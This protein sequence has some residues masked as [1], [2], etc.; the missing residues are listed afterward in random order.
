MHETMHM[1]TSL[2][3]HTY[4]TVHVHVSI[5][6]SVDDFKWCYHLEATCSPVQ[7]G[8]KPTMHRGDELAYCPDPSERRVAPCLHRN[9]TTCPIVNMTE[10][11]GQL[12]DGFHIEAQLGSIPMFLMVVALMQLGG[13]PSPVG[14]FGWV[15]WGGWMLIQ[16]AQLLVVV[17]N[18]I[19][20][21]FETK[22]VFDQFAL[23]TLQVPFLGISVL[24][25]F[26]STTSFFLPHVQL[27]CLTVVMYWLAL[28]SGG[29]AF[30]LRPKASAAIGRYSRLRRA[31][32]GYT[33]IDAVRSYFSHPRSQQS[34]DATLLTDTT[35]TRRARARFPVRSRKH[36]AAVP[37]AS[38]GPEG[39][40][41]GAH[42]PSSSSPPP[43]PP[44][45]GLV[46]PGA[47]PT[48]DIERHDDEE[49]G[50]A[51]W[52]DSPVSPPSGGHD[53]PTEQLVEQHLSTHG[54]VRR[55][56]L[57]LGSEEAEGASSH[58]A[59]APSARPAF[60]LVL[61]GSSSHV[62]ESARLDATW[63]E[64]AP[65]DSWRG[66]YSSRQ[67]TGPDQPP[68]SARSSELLA[69]R[70]H[71]LRRENGDLKDENRKLYHTVDRH[72]RRSR[73]YD[74]PNGAF[75]T[76]FRYLHMRLFVPFILLLL[77]IWGA[78]LAFAFSVVFLPI[79]AF[80]ATFTALLLQ[81]LV[82]LWNLANGHARGLQAARLK[83]L[84][85][86]R[87]DVSG[88]LTQLAKH[89]REVQKPQLWRPGTWPLVGDAILRWIGIR[90][91]WLKPAVHRLDLFGTEAAQAA[92]NGSEA[93][94]DPSSGISA[95][96]TK[97]NVALY[98]ARDEV[99]GDFYL[100][101]LRFAPP[102][103]SEVPWWQ[104]LL[105]YLGCP[106][107]VGE[108][109]KVSTHCGNSI[110]SARAGARR[111]DADMTEEERKRRDAEV[112]QTV[113][114]LL[115]TQLALTP[116]KTVM[117]Q[118]AW[119]V[120]SMFWWL[121]GRPKRLR[122]R[123]KLYSGLG[124]FWAFSQEARREH[125]LN[126]AAQEK[127]AREF[128]IRS[129]KFED[130]KEFVE[131]L[132]QEH[133]RRKRRT[134]RAGEDGVMDG[135]DPHG[136]SELA[137]LVRQHAVRTLQEWVRSVKMRSSGVKWLEQ[138]PGTFVP[139][140]AS[141]LKWRLVGRVSAFSS[142]PGVELVWQSEHSRD[143]KKRRHFS[144][145]FVRGASPPKAE[146]LERNRGL[147][148]MLAERFNAR[149]EA[150][151]DMVRQG[152]GE[153]AL[154]ALLCE[155]DISPAE[156]MELGF[157]PHQIKG[158]HC[159]KLGVR[160]VPSQRLEDAEL[161]DGETV[162]G[163]GSDIE[164]HYFKPDGFMEVSS[165]SLT[166]ALAKT[167]AD[168]AKR[169]R[170]PL[171]DSQLNG[172]PTYLECWRVTTPKEL[173]EA[174][175]HATQRS[176]IAVEGRYFRPVA[177]ARV[178][179]AGRV[180]IRRSA[181]RPLPRWHHINVQAMLLRK[182]VVAADQLDAELR[183]PLR[184]GA[185]RLLDCAWVLDGDGSTGSEPMAVLARRQELPENAFLSCEAALKLLDKAN[186][187]II[188]LTHCWLTQAHPD[189]H[190]VTLKAVRRYLNQLKEAGELMGYGQ[191]GLF[192]E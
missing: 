69:H 95:P 113:E 116:T 73:R 115:K 158:V 40:G 117:L 141:G 39:A 140:T 80:N 51:A 135:D 106:S 45:S 63:H 75:M 25:L 128:M 79:L 177:H 43:S 165:P 131:M 142:S 104:R 170:L 17:S 119:L 114:K 172:Q 59:A 144:A 171:S 182:D 33:W 183:A 26:A 112:E 149:M 62:A 123:L 6:P 108:K 86:M 139:P 161:E 55:F 89:E 147:A 35:R 22:L 38:A 90:I 130:H 166:A 164:F 8:V 132:R 152:K 30:E 7:L 15:L 76:F 146:Q 52:G 53:T 151:E 124:V 41:V 66:G 121:E 175:V 192:W 176:F 188:V 156:L 186:R 10:Q 100:P 99:L 64:D 110:G 125:D 126:R 102:R 13:I 84:Y 9:A 185:I 3:A 179:A 77:V 34:H 58:R 48:L 93:A 120:D 173:Q 138:R 88:A 153:D 67:P 98:L 11:M 134:A 54:S 78:S 127:E 187:S 184:D 70:L 136:E 178:P 91:G 92:S 24:S 29:R 160:R 71:E 101:K 154:A 23:C 85:D 50:E 133:Q 83:A 21:I 47:V 96:R 191:L 103:L 148:K 163:R 36:K 111:L 57:G 129:L 60:Q 1:Q 28:Y 27:K 49:G 14:S 72:R 190:G 19:L 109:P 20:S 159:I 162:E 174:E 16:L 155:D 157:Q 81:L 181:E 189:P 82:R 145:S 18:I 31:A 44:A 118:C 143:E 12:T 169:S 168:A 150:Y 5:F 65:M 61:P 68:L 37:K 167:I 46:R 107:L 180:S 105:Y 42:A 137:A 74:Q 94:P 32:P 56:L 4:S 2:A 97:Y 122:P 87:N